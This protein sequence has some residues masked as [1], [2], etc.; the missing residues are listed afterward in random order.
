MTYNA[1]L[2]ACEYSVGDA[3]EVEDAFRVACDTLDE[4]RSCDHLSPDDITYGTFLG[5]IA[6]LMPK[7]ETTNDLIELVFKRCCADGQLGPVA[8]K[9]LGDAA[10]VSRYRRLLGGVSAENVPAEWTCN[11]VTTS[12]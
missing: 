11:V 1:I 10:S 6:K 9:K 3:A 2:N 7:S 5:V 4:I 8:L 12:R